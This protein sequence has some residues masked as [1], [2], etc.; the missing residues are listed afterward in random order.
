[1]HH[2]LLTAVLGLAFLPAVAGL[3][4]P[5]GAAGSIAL[6]PDLPYQAEKRNRVSYQVDFRAVVTPPHGTKL[7]RV[8]MPIPPTDSAQAVSG[9][10]FE[11]FP[12]KV[13]PEVGREPVF[14]NTFAYFEFKEPRGA[15]MVIHRFR[16]VTHELRFGVD[17]AKVEAVKE[18]PPAFQPYLRSEGQAVVIS[19]AVRSQAA[20][21]GAGRSDEF[22][23]VRAVFEWIDGNL[24]YDHAAASLRA[25]SE[26][27]ITRRTGHCS[28]YHGLCSA[29]TR[30]LG[31]PARV[32]YGIN[33]F[34]KHSPSHCKAEVF[35]PGHGWVSFDLSETQ[36]LCQ[37]LAAE[38][39]LD[40]RRKEALAA[41]ARK[42]LLA[43]FRDNTWILLTRGTD[44]DLAPPARRRAAVVRTIYAEADGEALPEPDP[45]AA[46]K[47]EFSWMTLHAFQADREVSY[48][49]ADWKSLE[50]E[51]K[52]PR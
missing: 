4:S 30:D 12:D 2:H 21:I 29:L 7:L 22:E 20:L 26:W 51:T 32:T 52:G 6:D 1:V 40:A 3:A 9:S 35:L 27:A 47:R 11:T 49:F 36:K 16:A 42:R 23:R 45:G 17:P 15:Q 25:S 33:T 48:P 38:P 41:A 39:G 46:G 44:Y 5:D 13:E 50:E 34:P 19:D 8:W 24:R 14:G 18:W 37:K 43:G 28:D 31:Y 10:V